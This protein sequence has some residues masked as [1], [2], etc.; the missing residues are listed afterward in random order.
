VLSGFGRGHLAY[1][2]LSP[3]VI[4]GLAGLGAAMV[5]SG[6]GVI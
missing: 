6:G 5:A 2:R 1:G 3:L 4:A